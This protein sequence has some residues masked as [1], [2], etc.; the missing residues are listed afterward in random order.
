MSEGAAGDPTTE[1]PKAKRHLLG[2]QPVSIVLGIP[3]IT[4]SC[5]HEASQEPVALVD[6]TSFARSSADWPTDPF[7]STSTIPLPSTSSLS[8]VEARSAA[9]DYHPLVL[10]PTDEVD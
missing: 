4:L 6:L 8:M 2:D 10:H 3:P 5:P 1:L 9:L 7:P